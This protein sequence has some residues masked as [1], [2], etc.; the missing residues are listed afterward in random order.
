MFIGNG[1]GCSMPRKK[2]VKSDIDEDEKSPRA[3]ILFVGH[4]LDH[5]DLIDINDRY[6]GD[7]P[8]HC[9]EQGGLSIMYGLIK[10]KVTLFNLPLVRRPI[11]LFLIGVYRSL[12]S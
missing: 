8:S 2:S 4:L 10:P 6:Y 3:D 12:V 1:L 5:Q 7:L 11:L 9:A